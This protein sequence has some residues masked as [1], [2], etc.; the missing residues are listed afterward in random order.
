MSDCDF[1]L[2]K[3]RK[4]IFFV[5][6]TATFPAPCDCYVIALQIVMDSPFVLKVLK[7]ELSLKKVVLFI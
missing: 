5:P 4:C 6:N 1:G 3:K 7:G 2:T